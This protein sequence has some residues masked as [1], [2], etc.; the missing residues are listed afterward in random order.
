MQF[1]TLSRPGSEGAGK[2]H[3]R[4]VGADRL[5]AQGCQRARLGPQ[6]TVLQTPH[7]QVVEELVSNIGVVE[8]LTGFQHK[9]ANGRD[10]GL[11]VRQRAK[12]LAGLVTDPDRIRAE[13]QKAG[14]IVLPQISSC[15]V[16]PSA[17]A[18]AS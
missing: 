10:W 5:A 1:Y 12:E 3:W 7:A 17:S 2:Q 9:D 13:R 11:N 14:P 15:C 16:L 6:D 4:G 8:K 18:H